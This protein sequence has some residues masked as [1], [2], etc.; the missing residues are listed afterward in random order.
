MQNRKGKIFKG[1]S[2]DLIG[3][4][5]SILL[6]FI[7][8]PYFFNYVTKSQYGL[9]LVINGLVSVVSLIDVGTDLYLTKY[10]ADD[11]IF[12]SKNF[13]IKLISTIKIKILI[14]LLFLLLGGVFYAFIDKIVDIDIETIDIA[15]QCFL[16]SMGTLVSNLF[17]STF[18]NIFFGRHHYFLVNFISSLVL[19][20]PNLLTVVLLN[21]GFNIIAFPLTIFLV[22]IFQLTFFFIRFRILFNHIEFKMS[23]LNFSIDKE[24]YNFSKS[25]LILKW[26][27]VIRTQYILIVLNN[28]LGPVYSTRFNITSRLPLMLQTLTSK[29]SIVLFPTFSELYTSG[30]FS[31]LS[32][33]FFQINKILFRGSL[34][35]C[36]LFFGYSEIFIKLWVGADSYLGSFVLLLLLLHVFIYSA[37][38]FFGVVV[39]SFQNFN[40]WTFWCIVEIVGLTIIT[41]FMWDK[42]TINLIVGFFVFSSLINQIYLFTHALRILNISV[43]DFANKIFFYAIKSNISTLIGLVFLAKFFEINSW[44]GLIFSITGLFL[45]NILSVEGIKFYHLS[46]NS[47]WERLVKSFK[48]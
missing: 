39:F 26:I 3:Y 15:K 29:L 28:V 41:L 34:F 38:G 9:W 14:A 31:N 1:F 42:L 40:K 18:S 16:I 27:H 2:I 45:L 23:D 46:A 32:K 4:I 35:A 37:M 43:L 6:G 24:I 10:I 36:I 11:S 8:L 30:D 7:L 12:F 21:F 48:I 44:I 17:L 20:I 19:I 25:F 47:V 33:L 5:L 13:G 22:S